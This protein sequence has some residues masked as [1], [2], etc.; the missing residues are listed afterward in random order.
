MIEVAHGSNGNGNR[1]FCSSALPILPSSRDGGRDSNT[2]RLMNVLGTALRSK[3]I[4]K[5]G[6][7]LGA[8]M[9][10]GESV[11]NAAN[12][13]KR[14]SALSG[15]RESA[16]TVRGEANVSGCSAA[17]TTFMEAMLQL[18]TGA[19]TAHQLAGPLAMGGNSVTGMHRTV[20]PLLLLGG[21]GSNGGGGGS[22]NTQPLPRLAA[23]AGR[24]SEGSQA[25]GSY[26]G[27]MGSQSGHQPLP[28]ALPQSQPGISG[29][30][31]VGRRGGGG[32]AAAA[33]S[34]ACGS[35]PRETLLY[36]QLSLTHLR[37]QTSGAV[38]SGAG[39]AVGVHGTSGS[40]TAQASQAPQLAIRFP[41]YLYELSRAES[42]GTTNGNDS[43]DSAATPPP[44]MST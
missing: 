1:D 10:V 7:S 6:A 8:L 3:R 42:F 12:A 13:S 31:T 16:S 14:F 15:G 29:G 25:G 9:S 28:Q 32:G 34:A 22:R 41:S 40:W 19:A 20:S 44:V 11:G 36:S 2:S 43:S 39:T 18:A 38:K 27:T 24:D 35:P 5:G 33:A 4:S 23:L 37:G 30:L 26:G 21:G 17:P